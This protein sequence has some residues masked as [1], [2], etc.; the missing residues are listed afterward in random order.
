M[1]T[2]SRLQPE[3]GAAFGLSIR[4]TLK[5]SGV[6]A[7]GVFAVNQRLWFSCIGARLATLIGVRG[8]SIT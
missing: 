5:H 8:T 1:K 3:F 4:L 6:N 7:S 2:T